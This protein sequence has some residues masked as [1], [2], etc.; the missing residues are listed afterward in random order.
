MSE[1]VRTM[2]FGRELYATLLRVL[3]AAVGLLVLLW[4]LHTIQRVLL[5]VILS[6]ILALAINA[7]VTALERRGVGRGWGLLLVVAALAAGSV[8]LG[9]LAIPRLLEEIPR[10]MEEIPALAEGLGARVSALLGDHPEVQRQISRAFD[11]AADAMRDVWQ[12]LGGLL[13]GFLLSLF[14]VAMV[15]YMVANPRPL[16]GAYLHAMPEHLREPATRAFARGSQMVV[17]WVYSNVILGGMKAGASLVFLTFMEI[18]GAVVWAVIALFSALIERLGFYLMAIPPV[19]VAF[20]VDPVNAVWVLLFYWALSEFLGNF[21]APKI[22]ARTMK[23]NAVYIL[24][25]TLALA[26]AFGFL[27]VLIAAPVAGFLKAYFDEF[28]LRRQPADPHAGERIE[29]MMRR[30]PSLLQ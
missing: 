21:V 30:D 4:F 29:A 9:W 2:G 11:W 20:V 12:H 7:P 22:R 18:P 10:L 5:V 13:A 15:L 28:Y 24:V 16:L 27:G 1:T 19:V 3:F 25:M 17:G 8:G 23:L 6:L 14:V 26:Y